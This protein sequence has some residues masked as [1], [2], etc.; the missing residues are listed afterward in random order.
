MRGDLRCWAKMYRSLKKNCLSILSH[1]RNKWPYQTKPWICVG[2]WAL[3]WETLVSDECRVWFKD[4]IVPGC[5]KGYL[6]S[7][8]NWKTTCKHNKA[9]DAPPQTNWLDQKTKDLRLL[10]GRWLWHRYSRGK[11]QTILENNWGRGPSL[12]SS[13]NVLQDMPLSYVMFK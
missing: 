12:H 13:I 10:H 5:R 7:L 11:Q 4:L 3:G 1:F 2:P 9:C 6:F 8:A